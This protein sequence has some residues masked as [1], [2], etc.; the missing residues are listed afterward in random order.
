MK[1]YGFLS[2]L[3]V[4]SS[5]SYAAHEGGPVDGAIVEIVTP[6]GVVE[7]NAAGAVV[8]GGLGRIAGDDIA[9]EHLTDESFKVVDELV[10]EGVVG[11]TAFESVLEASSPDHWVDESFK[12]VDELV[13][14]GAVEP[15][16]N[17]SLMETVSRGHFLSDKNSKM[18]QIVDQLEQLQQELQELRGQVEAQ[19]HV[20]GQFERQRAQNKG[21]TVLGALGA[22]P[23]RV[24]GALGFDLSSPVND[25][26]TDKPSAQFS[27]SVMAAAQ[28]PRQ[29]ED[30]LIALLPEPWDSPN[31]VLDAEELDFQ[32]AYGVLR[33]GY[34]EYAIDLFQEFLSQY[35]MG[36][37]A[38]Q[39]QF[40]LAEAYRVNQMLDLADQAFETLIVKYPA[41]AQLPIALLKRSYLAIERNEIN[42]AKQFL[43]HVAISYPGSTAGH[44]AAKKLV[45]L[46]NTP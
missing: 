19:A 16:E 27:E 46:K 12:I 4:L 37:Y 5:A 41:S 34:T 18:F 43:T 35:P 7:A 11:N 28:P 8:E 20:I 29:K 36:Q 24:E 30:E 32:Q 40:W 23:D 1:I 44:I 45:E 25:L 10:G 22:R 15:L 14:E 38:D 13:E 39:A 17:D 33:N 31:Q 2:L 42:E 6:E 26:S 9:P 21:R 3:L